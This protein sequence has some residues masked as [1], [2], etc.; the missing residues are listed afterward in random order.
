MNI[1]TLHPTPPTMKHAGSISDFTGQR[2]QELLAAFRKVFQT[3]SFFDITHDYALVV[4][5][6]CSRYWISEERATAV[7]SAM[8]RGHSVH[9]AMRKSK[10]DMF[11]DIYCRVL[12]DRAADPDSPLSDIVFNVVN[13]RAPQFYMAPRHAREILYNMKKHRPQ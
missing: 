13:S 4:R 6:P 10:R 5:T 3:K 2:N 9:Y 7:V 11:I 8:L 1:I 12:F